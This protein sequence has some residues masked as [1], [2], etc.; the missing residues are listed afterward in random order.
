LPA[1]LSLF[2]QG[3]LGIF[4]FNSGGLQYKTR[5]Y[6]HKLKENSMKTA[7]DIIKDKQRDIVY[8]PWDQT[9]HQACLKMVANKFGAILVK[10]D[11]EFVGI[12]S[13][14]DLLR[15]ITAEGFDLGTAKVG[16]YMT[17]PLRTARHSTRIHKLEEMFL[18]LFLRH[19]LVEKEG[20]YIGLLSIGDVLRAGLLEKDRQFKEINDFVSWDYYENWKVGRRKKR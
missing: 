8:I 11:D 2:N 5:R 16:D 13:E 20:E 19:I 3:V 6:I 15:N 14:R 10:K 7:E 9:V 18:G 4:N 12:W 1:R 17:A